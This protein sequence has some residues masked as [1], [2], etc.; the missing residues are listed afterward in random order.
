MINKTID[1]YDNNAKKLIR[2]YD[3]ANMKEA[4]K[5]IEKYIKDTDKVLDIGF[6]SG[7]DLRYF[8]AK[9]ISI[10]GIDASKSFI[11]HFKDKYPDLKKNVFY[12]R[13]PHIEI[14][15]I[16]SHYFDLIFSMATW[17]HVPKK[18]H[19]ETILNIKKQLKKNGILILAYSCNSRRSDPRFFEKLT[20]AYV[21]KLFESSDFELVE[22]I[23]STDGLQRSEITWVTQVFKLN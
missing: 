8:A 21:Q 12:S 16:Q 17:M 9:N 11:K 18:F 1:F 20:P 5:C 15:N 2:D 14:E 19:K 6:G 4:Y 7:R 22:Q 23:Q 13:L 3:N 10:Y